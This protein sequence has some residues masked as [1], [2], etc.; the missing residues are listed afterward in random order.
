MIPEKVTSISHYHQYIGLPQPKH[1]LLSLIHFDEVKN[2]PILESISIQIPFYS[3]GLKRNINTKL[4]Y[5]QQH[6]DFDSGILTFM[7]PGQILSIKHE[8]GSEIKQSGWLL[9]IHPDF[10]WNNPLAK[11]IKQ[12]GYFDYSVNEALFLSEY[13]EEII[14]LTM[15]DIQREYL[16]N[17]DKFSTNIINALIEVLLKYAER[18]YSRQ[19]ITRKITNHTILQK[20]EEVL[21]RYFTDDTA[22]IN[23]LPTVNY[24][25]ET[26][27]ISPNYLSNLL[28]ELTG[29]STQQHIHNK[30][31]EK[32]K[33]KLTTTRLSISEI[34]YSLGFE[35]QQSFTKLF[36]AKVNCSPLKFRNSFN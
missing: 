34:A 23:K 25:A 7:A 17:I 29:Q 10:L 14:I 20:L 2:W 28:S 36:K 4:K 22:L 12:Y 3:I 24:I 18:F 9:L 11:S 30:L 16:A 6:Y 19:F 15:L 1:P 21:N 26:L 5:G 33:E 8:K 32:A 31:I 35:H 27:C 13:E